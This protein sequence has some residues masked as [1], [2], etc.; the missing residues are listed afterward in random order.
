MLRAAIHKK[1]SNNKETHDK[2]MREGKRKEIILKIK[3]FILQDDRKPTFLSY[4]S[5]VSKTFKIILFSIYKPSSKALFA[6]INTC[7]KSSPL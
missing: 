1:A 5:K 3:F 6:Q 7:K 2:R 4:I